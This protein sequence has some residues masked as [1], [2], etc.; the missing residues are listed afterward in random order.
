MANNPNPGS[1]EIREIIG[2]N[3]GTSYQLDIVSQIADTLRGEYYNPA[4]MGRYIIAEMTNDFAFGRME[5]FINDLADDLDSSIPASGALIVLAIAQLAEEIAY[6][7]YLDS[8]RHPLG[9][10][11]EYAELA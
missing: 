1:E 9:G 3:L 10:W 11:V 5:V 4:A 7:N 6:G 8:Y 2:K